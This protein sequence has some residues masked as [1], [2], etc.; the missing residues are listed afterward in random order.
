MIQ[1]HRMLGLVAIASSCT[2]GKGP[3][4]TAGARRLVVGCAA[5]GRRCVVAAVAVLALLAF[6]TAPARAAPVTVDLQLD[7][8]AGP[9]IEPRL[10]GFNWRAGGQAVAPLHPG[11]VRSFA[12]RLARISPAP[13]VLDFS[14]GDAELDAVEATGAIP[15]IVLIERPPWDAGAG[16]AGYELVVEAV[17][18]HYLVTRPAAGHRPV[19]VESGNEPEFPPT[20]HGQL[21]Q[22][23]ADDVAAQVRALVRVETGAGV[24]ARYG[25]PG[26]LFADPAIAALFVAAAR[27]AGRVPDFVSWHAY[28][29][30]P[31]L[32]P[33][34]PEDRSSP[35]AVAV[36][37]A[38]HGIN[39]VASPTILG[40]G[41]D[42]MRAA[43]T[44]AMLPGEPT[45][46]LL[47]TEWNTSSGG[48]DRRNDTPVGA[49]HTVGSLIEMHT[50]GLDGSTF[51]AAVDRHCSDPAVNPTGATFCGDWGT[52][53]ASGV[54][55]PVWHAFDLWQTMAGPTRSVAGADPNAGLWAIAA[56]DAR[57]S[58]TRVLAASFSV[59]QPVDRT[60][61]IALPAAAV[62]RNARVRHIDTAHPSAAAERLAPLGAG[63]TSVDVDLPANSVVLLELEAATSAQ[64]P[65]LAALP[66]P[67]SAAPLP[68]TGP[69]E[70]SGPLGALGIALGVAVCWLLGAARRVDD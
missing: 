57:T 61:R 2:A 30:A 47:I 21:P 22:E 3:T 24:H 49:A 68:A 9:P 6:I 53:S 67:G 14:A 39:P 46:E 50:R 29:N 58:T 26:A 35:E 18:R 11:L 69:S 34:G 36:W 13:G 44:A 55:K 70:A 20:S 45:P 40:A 7:A 65:A 42:V 10:V 48:L 19:W 31:L 54:H 43:V 59:S 33:D 32:G 37:Q 12:V 41:I 28:P 1:A 66:A 15:M 64:V 63:A 16:S 8:T 4:R 51:F 62:P 56:D 23:L 25:G 52:A 38:L 27:N 5:V 17:L 60:L